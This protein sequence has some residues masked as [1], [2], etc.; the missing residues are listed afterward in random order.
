M[1]HVLP[2]GIYLGFKGWM[3]WLWLVH[4]SPHVSAL[5]T[6]SILAATLP[7]WA[8]YLRCWLGDPGVIS[9]PRQDKLEGVRS[10]FEGKR[11]VGCLV[12]TSYFIIFRK[13]RHYSFLLSLS[14]ENFKYFFAKWHSNKLSPQLLLQ[15]KLYIIFPAAL[16]L[17]R[18]AGRA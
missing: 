17:S 13:S 16:P 15:I 8:T 5:T 7:V 2:V 10:M 11:S 4:V 18:T 9:A 6:C 1:P 3:Y 14:R 12:A